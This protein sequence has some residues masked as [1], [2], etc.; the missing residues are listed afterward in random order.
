MASKGELKSILTNMRHHKFGT[1]NV[2]GKRTIFL[3][4]DLETARGN[5]FCFYCRSSSRKRHVAKHV[6]CDAIKD[7]SS[8]AQIP[9]LDREI[10]IY[11][12]DIGDAFY[13]VLKEY[14]H[15][16]SSMFDPEIDAGTRMDE[17]VY[18][19]NVEELTFDD[20]SFDIVISEDI[21]EHVRN[22]KKGFESV[23]RVLKPGGYHIFT[24]PFNFHIPTIV[25]VD[26]STQEDIHL[27]PPEYHGDRIRGHI[28]A[29]RTFGFDLF[30]TLES[31][32]FETTAHLSKYEDQK[33][34][35]LDSY[36]FV[37]QK[38]S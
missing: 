18:C 6:I 27:L 10:S 14:P 2:C 13:K 35:I 20:E 5:M 24:V 15:F 22:F 36:V 23:V 8:I 31:L 16:F 3:C 38:K 7:V 25:R 37:S 1:C 21:F 26:T 12:L 17:R 19:Q 29:Y 32:G 28:L 11:V 4:T 30:D 34:G 33:N 9:A